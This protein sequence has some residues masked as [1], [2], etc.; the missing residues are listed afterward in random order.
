MLFCEH[1]KVALLQN[2]ELDLII[3]SSCSSGFS[4]IHGNKC[5]PEDKLSITVASKR[6]SLA[7]FLLD[8][9]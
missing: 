2:F 8:F 1:Q 6:A 3:V 9:A 7:E 4:I 5:L